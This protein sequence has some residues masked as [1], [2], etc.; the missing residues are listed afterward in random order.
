MYQNMFAADKLDKPYCPTIKPCWIPQISN[1]IPKNN[2][3]MSTCTKVEDYDCML[4]IFARIKLAVSPKCEEHCEESTYRVSKSQTP[5]PLTMLVRI[6]L[7]KISVV[8]NQIALSATLLFTKPWHHS[9]R[10]LLCKRYHINIYWVWGIFSDLNYKD[11]DFPTKNWF[12]QM[13]FQYPTFSFMMW[14]RWW[15]QLE[16]HWVYFLASH[17]CKWVIGSSIEWENHDWDESRFQEHWQK[18]VG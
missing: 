2:S 5:I 18:N 6:M 14:Q 3:V 4:A 13:I 12:L 1:F 7:N 15:D 9:N 17:V 8:A 16:D 11:H 10:T